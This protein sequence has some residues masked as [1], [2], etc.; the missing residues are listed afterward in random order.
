MTDMSTVSCD[1][2]ATFIRQRAE[3]RIEA[4]LLR[5]YLQQVAH[6]S[7]ERLL[8]EFHEE[9]AATNLELGPKHDLCFRWSGKYTIVLR[10]QAL[11]VLML[12]DNTVLIEFEG[13]TDG[14]GFWKIDA[15]AARGI[16]WWRQF[17]PEKRVLTGMGYSAQELVTA[18]LVRLVELGLSEL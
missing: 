11:T 4:Q 18:T 15:E 7:F 5:D 14:R 13:I 8:E 12:D 17:D 3:S 10:E 16:I 1:S 6:I 9:V 2:L